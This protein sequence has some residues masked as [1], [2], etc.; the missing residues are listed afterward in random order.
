VLHPDRP[1]RDEAFV[2]WAGGILMSTSATSG[3][4]R[5]TSRSSVGVPGLRDDVDPGA[6]EQIDDALPGQHE[7]L[8][9][10]YS[11]G[12]SAQHAVATVDGARRAHRRGRAVTVSPCWPTN[13]WWL[14]V[15][16]LALG[17]EQC[18]PRRSSVTD[19]EWDE[20]WDNL[21]G[22]V[23]RTHVMLS[24][25]VIAAIDDLVGQRGR[26]RF[27]DAAAREKLERLH[28]DQALATAAGIIVSPDYPQFT[29][30]AAINEWVR[31]QRRTEEV[32]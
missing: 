2:G 7:I 28:L 24:D 16:C 17:R 4:V 19:L 29:D 31:A 30:Q 11:H 27:L 5:S 3:L 10:H 20:Q 12:I 26:S 15:R 23:G 22:T 25:D 32:R 13:A 18:F 6:V 14:P 1:G 9:H 21:E 8:D